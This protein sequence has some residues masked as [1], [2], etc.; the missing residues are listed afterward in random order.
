[1]KKLV[2]LGAIAVAAALVGDRCLEAQAAERLAWQAP[3]SAKTA[4]R[5]ASTRTDQ[6]TAALRQAAEANKYLFIFFW[7]QQTTQTDAAWKA[8]APAVK[9]LADR[10]TSVS[11]R[12]TDPAEKAIVDRFDVS[13]APMPLVLAVAPNGAITRGISAKFDEAQLRDAFVS[14]CTAKCL[15][16]LQDRKLVLLCIQNEVPP[17]GQPA[18]Q[19][20]VQDFK[21]D[22]QY[23]GNTEVVVL[24]PN[25]AVE[26]AFVKQFQVDAKSPEP[27][28][29]LMAPPGSVVGK[30]VGPVSKSQL[31][32]KLVSAQS[33]PCA[34]G[35]CG[36]GGCGPKK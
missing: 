25:E 20:G 34:G 12:A 33:N 31:V 30:F 35:K 23:A 21:A 6:G 27:V 16:G 11:I 19:R 14:P 22:A 29:V 18:L 36:P 4:A 9:K 1:M 2:A 7:K 24:N 17:Q 5:P 26:S 15:K 28:T 10:A 13:R 8:F 3:S 32:A